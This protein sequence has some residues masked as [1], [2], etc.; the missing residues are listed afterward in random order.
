MCS[1]HWLLGTLG[2]DLYLG[3]LH[4]VYNSDRLKMLQFFRIMKSLVEI[5]MCVD[6]LLDVEFMVRSHFAKC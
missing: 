2:L 3:I 5:I 4:C 6:K 1:K